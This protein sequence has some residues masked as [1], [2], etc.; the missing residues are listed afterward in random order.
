M[1]MVPDKPRQIWPRQCGVANESLERC[2]I[3]YTMVS[4]K[5]ER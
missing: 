4:P 2:N 1:A 3:A 5:K